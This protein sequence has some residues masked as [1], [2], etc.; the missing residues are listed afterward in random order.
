MLKITNEMGVVMN[1]DDLL[2]PN[3]FIEGTDIPRPRNMKPNETSEEYIKFLRDFYSRYSFKKD[4]KKKLDFSS[5]SDE[6][7]T[8]RIQDLY[9]FIAHQEN[10]LE[11]NSEI[12]NEYGALIQEE[13]RRKQAKEATKTIPTAEDYHMNKEAYDDYVAEGYEPGTEDFERAA[14][15]DGQ[16]FTPIALKEVSKDVSDNKENKQTPDN[17]K[18]VDDNKNQETPDTSKDA[19]KENVSSEQKSENKDQ[20]DNVKFGKDGLFKEA[21][22]ICSNDEGLYFINQSAARRFNINS[23][24]VQTTD[25]RIKLFPITKEQIQQ[26]YNESLKDY[27]DFYLISVS[28][29]DMIKKTKAEIGLRE[30][31]ESLS[32]DELLDIIISLD[33]SNNS[34]NINSVGNGLSN[35]DRYKILTDV[36]NKK[37]KANNKIDVKTTTENKEDNSHNTVKT[38]NKEEKTSESSKEPKATNSKEKQ[39]KDKVVTIYSDEDNNC[40]V[41]ENTA[42]KFNITGNPIDFN[43]VKLFKL[44]EEQVKK[45]LNE[46]QKSDTDFTV[47]S[48]LI[49][50]LTK[51]ENT[52][53]E[54]VNTENK[55]EEAK[56]S[57]KTDSS[58]TKS[59]ENTEY[60]TQDALDFLNEAFPKVHKKEKTNN[61]ADTKT[62]SKEENKKDVAKKDN[63]QEKEQK[64]SKGKNK[65]VK[66]KKAR[67]KSFLKAISGL[68]KRIFKKIDKVNI[69]EKLVDAISKKYSIIDFDED[70]EEVQNAKS[71]ELQ[72]YVEEKLRENNLDKDDLI[73]KIG[74][75]YYLVTDNIDDDIVITDIFNKIVT[76]YANVLSKEEDEEEV[77]TSGRAR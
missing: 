49:T 32:P 59:T 16:P 47:E 44:S 71:E 26:I 39:E 14:R 41:D 74:K 77:R 21:V 40:Y 75:K 53:E 2:S 30:Y 56:E 25:V 45:I 13:N 37:T 34:Q 23:E 10:G 55:Q 9:N 3:E 8:S 43:N 72:R 76:D 54:K 33:R 62:P 70:T 69:M 60:S 6:E 5:L 11:E 35:Y 7:L 36:Y 20:I 48:K 42:K 68:F 1:N 50:S 67:K 65:V 46:S 61:N 15:L 38:D 4:E 31:A 28:L 63:K 73:Y 12:A 18:V 29:E 64:S 57:K 27:S 24:P 17:N 22:S 51:D 52:S 66:A 19:A 58:D